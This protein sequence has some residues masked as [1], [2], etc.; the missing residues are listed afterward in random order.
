L[1]GGW[2]SAQS[3]LVLTPPITK[4][5]MRAS[6]STIFS[7]LFILFGFAQ[8]VVLTV[9]PVEALNVLGEARLVSLAYLGVGLAGFAGRL[10]LPLLVRRFQ[11][12]GVLALGAGCL[13]ASGLLLLTA[14]VAGLV[15]GLLLNVFA[16]GCLEIV[17]NLCVLDQIPRA[18]LGRFEAKRIFFGATPYT[19]GPWLG[20]W[21][22]IN[23]VVWLPFLVSAASGIA[24]ML[25]LRGSIAAEPR[26][27]APPRPPQN[28]LRSVRR[29]FAQPRLRLAWV[30]SVG[31]SSWWSMFQVYAP[32]YAVQSGLGAELGG[33]IV[34]TGLGMMW[35]VP[36]WGWLGRRYGVRKLFVAGY[37]ASGVVTLVTALLMQSAWLGAIALI[38][39]A[40]ATEVLD[41]AGNSLYLRAV[42]PYERSE[43]TAVF[44]SYRDA[45]QL[46]PPAV[47]TALLT[48][49][50]LPAVFVAGG[51]MMLGMAGLSRYIP[52]RF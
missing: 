41:G 6:R 31:R 19:V 24:L 8:T 12:S 3:N 33:A 15:L 28:P 40:L 26:R 35:T 5:A 10:S 29:F 45:T 38:L 22:Q 52:R 51:M 44:A 30:L 14:T 4:R 23:V 48:F 34:S 50:E 2:V 27:R 49:F 18:E 42:H 11:R 39:G 16:L 47:F 17:L 1:G 37:A 13:C 36:L 32:I 21:L 20:V 25:S 9:L 43:M 46:L 7:A